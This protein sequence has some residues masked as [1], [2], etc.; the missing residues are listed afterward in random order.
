MRSGACGWLVLDHPADVMIEVTGETFWD[1][2][3]NAARG[4]NHFLGEIVSEEPA[5]LE[6]LKIEGDTLEEQLVNFLRELLFYFVTTSTL[7]TDIDLSGQNDKG[8]M[9]E[10]FF[11]LAE[12]GPNSLEVKGITYHGLSVEKNKEGYVARLVFDV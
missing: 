1:L 2:C 4:L 9:V 12:I 11:K 7:V 6:R 3:Q 10:A 8:L 5:E